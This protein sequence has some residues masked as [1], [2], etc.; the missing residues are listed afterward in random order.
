MNEYEIVDCGHYAV[1][2][3]WGGKEDED[4]QVVAIHSKEE[5]E[6]LI[7]KLKEFVETISAKQ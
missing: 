3:L 1:L 5:A 7:A 4:W 6:K 2:Y